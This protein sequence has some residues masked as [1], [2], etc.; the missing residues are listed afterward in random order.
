MSGSQACILPTSQRC[1]GPKIFSDVQ[2]FLGLKIFGQ[3][4]KPSGHE[5][6]FVPGQGCASPRPLGLLNTC[7]CY[8]INCC[9]L[10]NLSNKI[11]L[12]G[13]IMVPTATVLKAPL[14][15]TFLNLFCS[16]EQHYRSIRLPGLGSL[17]P[18]ILSYLILSSF[19]SPSPPPH[20][21]LNLFLFNF[22]SFHF[23]GQEKPKE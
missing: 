22:F 5:K 23:F 3:F 21:H 10:G 18:S 14:I 2:Y 11:I 1:F 13:Y 6:K 12:E 4:E 7:I 9:W 15:A 8:C 17:G 19:F 16:R 20:R